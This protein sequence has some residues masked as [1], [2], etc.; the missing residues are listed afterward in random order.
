MIVVTIGAETPASP[1]KRDAKRSLR[2]PARRQ[3]RWLDLLDVVIAHAAL[4]LPAPAAGHREPE[5]FLG[6][7][8]RE[9]A[10]DAALV[11][12]EDAV[13]E[14]EDLLELERDE[15]HRAAGVALLD[16]AAVDELDRADVETARRL[17]G[18]QHL[19]IAVDLA[20]EHHLL[21]VAAGERAGRRRRPAA[22]DVEL[23]R[24]AGARA[25]PSRRG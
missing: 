13:G 12:D 15:E 18:D 2:R 21:L 22:A 7:R 4:L 9:L 1:P 3:A 24:A 20:R 10:D 17:R 19:R 25:R 8:R 14:R 23:L 5:L 6:R 16:E 11:D